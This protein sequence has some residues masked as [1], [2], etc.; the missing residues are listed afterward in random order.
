MSDPLT[1]AAAAVQ[2][3][4]D[5]A[6]A[7]HRIRD[8]L[9]TAIH[10][11]KQ[12][13]TATDAWYNTVPHYGPLW[14]SRSDAR[15]TADDVNKI[16]RE[17]DYAL[18]EIDRRVTRIQNRSQSQALTPAPEPEPKPEPVTPAYVERYVIER[19][20]TVTICD[21]AHPVKLPRNQWTQG[22][23]A[24]GTYG[25]IKGYQCQGGEE[26]ER[27]EWH[28]WDNERDDYAFMDCFYPTKKQAVQ[29]LADHL[30]TKE[31]GQ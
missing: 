30:K 31:A 14:D 13:K 8:D 17:V 5:V 21:E 1:P 22:W 28:V 2:A 16:V 6:K 11:A 3:V 27:W 19:Q 18:K 23:K 26:H 12:A 20:P 7:L 25:T 29:A 24:D 9:N 10:L 15:Y 4:E